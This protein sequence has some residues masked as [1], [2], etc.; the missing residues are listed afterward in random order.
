MITVS[1]SRM[2]TYLSCPYSHY[3]RYVKGLKKKGKSRPLS[4]GSDFHKLLEVRA[5]RKKVK[6]AYKAQK[7]NYYNLDYSSQADLGDD[8]LDALKSIFVD[9]MK[10]YKNTPMPQVT[11]RPFEIPIGKYKGELIVFNGIIDELYET[12]EGIVIGEHKTFNRKPDMLFVVMNTQK[13]LYAKA[14][15]HITGSLPI[16]VQWDYIRSTPAQLPVWLEKSQKFSEAKNNNIT[17]FSWIRACKERGIT[18]ESILRKG[19]ELYEGNIFNFFFRLS[20]DVLPTM[21]NEIYD[22]FKYTA[23]EIVRHGDKN[24][25]RHTGTNCSWCEYKDICY[26]ELTGGDVNYIKQR[27][28]TKRS[29]A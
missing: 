14:V 20:D 27:D 16:S 3:L 21:V 4:F 13:C 1:Y 15:E 29:E 5:D 9:Y 22:G 18:D 24:K 8:Y 10:I 17:P 12:D 6:Q 23:K 28:Y 25:T 26:A 19:K 2:Q 11:E 7:E